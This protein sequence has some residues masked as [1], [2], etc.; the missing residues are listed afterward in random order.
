MMRGGRR[1]ALGHA[2]IRPY[3]QHHLALFVVALEVGWSCVVVF[4]VA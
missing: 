4:V 2:Q 1:R 3:Y